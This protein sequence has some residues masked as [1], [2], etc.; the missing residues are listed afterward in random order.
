M[1]Y[2]GQLFYQLD[3]LAGHPNCSRE[4]YAQLWE[5][6]GFFST[7]TARFKTWNAL[8]AP[9]DRSLIQGNTLS[10][11]AEPLVFQTQNRWDQIRGA[12]LE[13]ETL[14][15]LDLKLKPLVSDEVRQAILE[16]LTYFSKGFF[17]S[18]WQETG[19]AQSIQLLRAYADVFTQ[20][21]INSVIEDIARFYESPASLAP[22]KF[23]LML[24]APG[25]EQLSLAE[26]IL[27]H[28]VIE[29]SPSQ[30]PHSQLDVMIH[31]MTHYFFK[32]LPATTQAKIQGF[33][34]QQPEAYAMSA[35]HLFDE[36][37]ATAIGT[38]KR[39]SLTP[40]LF[41][42]PTAHTQRFF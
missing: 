12:A 29:V 13:S 41:Y 37:L 16:Q 27:N 22:L 26:Q 1:R 3:C 23:H 39:K 25:A 34:A 30:S 20:Y 9:L 5:Q 35:Y 19:K 36:S 32:Q 8:K 14:E 11:L 17:E 4:Q 15:D 38:H 31:E 21:K 42:E 18:W 24:Q 7:E 10:N 28:G 6:N 2:I 33:F 40:R